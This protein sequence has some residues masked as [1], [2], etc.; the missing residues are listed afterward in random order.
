MI[1]KEIIGL[2]NKRGVSFRNVHV[3]GHSLGA[4]I[5]G[6]T[7]KEVFKSTRSKIY[8]ITGLD[9]AGPLF[10]VPLQNKMNRLSDQD[11]TF[12]EILHTDGGVLGFLTPLGTS[13]FFPNGGK[14]IQ[15]K[16][17]FNLKN[18]TEACK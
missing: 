5:A 10:E 14:F 11:A 9:P 8:W 3:I 16:C 18:L 15:P 17:N 4:H 7:G 12:V 1:A 2:H 13:D 6:F